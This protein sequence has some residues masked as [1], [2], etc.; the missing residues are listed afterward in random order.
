[1]RTRFSL[2]GSLLLVALLL[3]GCNGADESETADGDGIAL[4]ARSAAEFTKSGFVFGAVNPTAAP[5]GEDLVVIN[6][7]LEDGKV[8]GATNEE[9]PAAGAALLS[10]DGTMRALP[11]PP[12][13]GTARTLV[14]AGNSVVLIAADCS[15]CDR[16]RLSA[17]RLADDRSSWEQVEIPSDIPK[18]LSGDS[19]IWYVGRS[20]AFAVAAADGVYLK[21]DKS[22]AISRIEMPEQGSRTQQAVCVARGDGNL[23]RIQFELADQGPAVGD[24][25]VEPSTS[26]P[27]ADPQQGVTSDPDSTFQ[28][29][30]EYGSPRAW[31]LD[32]DDAD[33]QWAELPTA[34]LKE[35]LLGP[36]TVCGLN[37]P[38]I[39]A[40]GT[41][42]SFD[43]GEWRTIP[44]A[45]PDWA[46][47]PSALISTS[48]TTETGAVFTVPVGTE[49]VLERT[50]GG[51]WI[52]NGTPASA[53][54]G[55]GTSVVAFA[56]NNTAVFVSP[57]R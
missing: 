34:P 18:E 43:G 33:S 32:L 24:T 4:G 49:R 57:T 55:A 35:R 15:N 9:S 26:S 42:I 29:L 40:G 37:G 23:Y 28:G 20:P 21:V 5:A 3:G 48:V 19:E 47:S 16:P 52:D 56:K 1:M 17:H 54:V 8:Y 7:Y 10:P 53:L 13:V 36:Q 46:R 41:E 12:P 51:A 30:I 50:E 27:P 45:L 38:I 11:S 25:A 2:V 31:S 6:S 22:G 44:I 39:V 14:P